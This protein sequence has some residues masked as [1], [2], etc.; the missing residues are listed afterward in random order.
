MKTS[1]SIPLDTKVS[2]LEALGVPMFQ[3]QTT[4]KPFFY[5]WAEQYEDQQQSVHWIPREIPMGPD[6]ADWAP[7]AERLTDAE[8]NLI[9]N[10]VRLFTQSDIDVNDNY[11]DK[12]IN[13]LRNPEIRRMLTVF[14]SFETIHIKA[15]SY[16]IESLKL[17]EST[18]HEFMDIEEMRAKHD[19]LKSYKN[20][21]LRELLI[22]MACFPA[23]V[24][25]LQLFA[26]FAIL[27]N[28]TRFG[29]MKQTGQLV[30]WSI[31]DETIHV[32]A[33]I[34]MWK[35][36]MSE[37]GVDVSEI[38]DEILEAAKTFVKL[39]D[40]FIDR[41]F[42]IGEVRGATAD[43]FKGYVRYM[44]DIRLSQLGLEP[45]YGILEHPIEWI[46]ALTGQEH[47]NF[48]ENRATEYSKASATGSWENAWETFGEVVDRNG[49]HHPAEAIHSRQRESG[50]AQTLF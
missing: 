22:T 19:Y 1:L 16:I 9:L 33:G 35:Q 44:A 3:P 32:N 13:T 28:F 24:E 41:A 49:E 4:Y 46:D 34:Q 29:R 14:N 37:V 26:S 17:P 42:E 10:I 2:K 11:N 8:R 38:K 45:Y 5:P 39:E 25:G 15:Y 6:M 18:Y 36:L 12:F 31:R 30:S 20:E 7:Q 48:F 50:V 47:T 23:F 27:L 21:N 40:A 43:D